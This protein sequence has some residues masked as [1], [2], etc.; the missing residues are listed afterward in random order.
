MTCKYWRFRN[1]E[2]SIIS[3]N[4]ILNLYM[5]IKTKDFIGM[6]MCRKFFM[7]FTR[8]RRYANHRDGNKYDKNGNVKPQ[9]ADALTCEKA[10]CVQF[11]KRPET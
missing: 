2:E 7:G 3:S 11:S 9:E 1:I 10:K 4:T 8:A 6:D 5:N